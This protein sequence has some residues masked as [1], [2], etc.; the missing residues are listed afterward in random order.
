ME[1][2][3]VVRVRISFKEKSKRE[4]NISAGREDPKA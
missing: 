3:G 1:N 4:L 2:F